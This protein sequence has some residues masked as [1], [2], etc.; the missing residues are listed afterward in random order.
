MNAGKRLGQAGDLRG[1]GVQQGTLPE[2][3]Q[4]W[5]EPAEQVDLMLLSAHPDDE[6][7]WFGGLL[8]YYAG[9]AAEGMPGGML[10]LQC[11]PSPPG[12][13][14]QPVDLRR[15]GVSRFAGYQDYLTSTLKDMYQYWDKQSLYQDVCNLYRQ[16]R[17]QVVVAHDKHGGIRPRSAPGGVRRRAQGPQSWPRTKPSA[18]AR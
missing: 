9:G 1:D 5:R 13:A 4:V 12:A 8:P 17:P 18:W 2:D 3:V 16:Y 10:C 6:V 11:L 15:S 7:L 14:G